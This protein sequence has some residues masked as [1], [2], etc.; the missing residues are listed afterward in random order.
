MRV[1]KSSAAQQCIM[2]RQI[3]ISS[4]CLSAA[5]GAPR[6]SGTVCGT[7]GYDVMVLLLLLLQTS[8]ARRYERHV[9]LHGLRCRKSHT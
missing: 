8:E 5:A 6:L 9:S 4:I 2:Q 7:S 1:H 3:A